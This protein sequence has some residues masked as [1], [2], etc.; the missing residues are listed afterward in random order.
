VRT[1]RPVS[2]LQLELRAGAADTEI[3]ARV[4][5]REV[6][7]PVAADRR[8]AIVISLPPGFPNKHARPVESPG[9][10]YIWMLTLESSAG[11]V[12]A[13]LEPGSTDTRLLGVLVRPMV[14]P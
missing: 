5:D 6:T 3:T 9:P 2:R 4:G 13:D 7:V 1:D 11:F 8:A 10:S 12:P 14:F